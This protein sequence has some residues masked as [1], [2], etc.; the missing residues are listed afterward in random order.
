M[1]SS[2]KGMVKQAWKYTIGGR[3]DTR[4]FV[5]SVSEMAKESEEMAS[6]IAQQDLTDEFEVWQK[7]RNQ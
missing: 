2:Y 6:F 4:D 7:R 1:S 5:T 3:W